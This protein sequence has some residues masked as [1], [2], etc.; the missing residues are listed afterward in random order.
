MFG[1]WKRRYADAVGI[2]RN[3]DIT[4]NGLEIERDAVYDQ[5]KTLH[6]KLQSLQKLL[7]QAKQQNTELEFASQE[8]DAMLCD[9]QKKNDKLLGEINLRDVKI[10]QLNTQID[11]Q[12]KNI[13]TLGR[14]LRDIHTAF[15][16]MQDVLDPPNIKA[17]FPPK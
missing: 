3:R 9:E 4:I 12:R 5:N 11:Q 8:F 17:D 10:E 6:S 7:N 14:K 1:H 16:V 2:I 15:K 13:E